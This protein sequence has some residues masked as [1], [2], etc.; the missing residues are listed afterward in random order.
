MYASGR[1]VQPADWAEVDVVIMCVRV[2]LLGP[3][4]ANFAFAFVDALARRVADAQV[5][6]GGLRPD[7]PTPPRG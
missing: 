5:M 1:F 6:P 7:R 3:Q 2:W 4:L